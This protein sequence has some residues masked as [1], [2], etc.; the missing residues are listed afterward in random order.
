MDLLQLNDKEIRAS[1]IV[2]LQNQT[3]RPRA[4]VEE[5]RVHNGNAI[6]D[7]VALY[8][9]AHC[10]EIKGDAD[11]VERILTQGKYYNLSFR[12]ITL[13]T[14]LKH[15]KKALKLAP[16]YWGVMVAE[17]H[18][19]QVK[20]KYIRRAKN[21]PNFDKTTA[22]LTLWKDEMLD[23]V[24]SKKKNKNSSRAILAEL[25]AGNKR[26][27]ELSKNITMTLVDRY[28]VNKYNQLACK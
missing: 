19:C 16:A 8:S 14:T 25:I 6:A 27:L 12:K 22:L 5:L 23:L 10:F 1:L 20:I 26:K 4:I 18:D 21:N 24:E 2:K 15:V 13:V 7:V 11:K 17:D 3:I 9:E 28:K